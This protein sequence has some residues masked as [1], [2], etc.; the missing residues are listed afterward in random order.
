MKI[1]DPL[2]GS[3]VRYNVYN[4]FQSKTGQKIHEIISTMPYCTQQTLEKTK[5]QSRMDNLETQATLGTRLSTKT[6]KTKKK[7]NM[8][9]KKCVHHK[10]RP[11]I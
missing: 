10:I 1:E 5:G 11:S 2:Y 3:D 4:I 8:E 7:H 6:K 9:N